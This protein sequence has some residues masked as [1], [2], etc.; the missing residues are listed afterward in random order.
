M[1]DAR[2]HEK[3]FKSAVDP[4]LLSVYSGIRCPIY[5]GDTISESVVKEVFE[6]VEKVASVEWIPGQKYFY[7][8]LV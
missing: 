2:A 3:V 6:Y 1:M 7:G 8:N 4:T 5:Y